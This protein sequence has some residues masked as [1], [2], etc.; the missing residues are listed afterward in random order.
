MS[1]AV[2]VES[3]FPETKLKKLP[4]ESHLSTQPCPKNSGRKAP[5]CQAGL[6]PGITVFHV[7]CIE[8]SL[9]SGQKNLGNA[10]VDDK[11]E[12]S[13]LVI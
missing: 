5:I 10:D 3:L 8:E 9:K 4:I 13:L 12:L 7:L 1:S 6:Q 11:V 2:L